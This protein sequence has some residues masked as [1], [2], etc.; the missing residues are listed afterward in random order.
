MRRLHGAAR[1]AEPSALLLAPS[2][3]THRQ[4]W[5][6]GTPLSGGQEK[7]ASPLASTRCS[8]MPGCLQVGGVIAHLDMDLLECAAAELDMLTRLLQAAHATALLT[9]AQTAI[10]RQTE[11]PPERR[12][13]QWC[14]A[15]EES[16][17]L[18]A[19]ISQTGC[20]A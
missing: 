11:Q 19:L 1:P 2:N 17:D 9:P 10:G 16:P 14:D 15:E 5:E 12:C 4:L 7:H 13:A 20:A 6:L 18:D 3:M 8:A